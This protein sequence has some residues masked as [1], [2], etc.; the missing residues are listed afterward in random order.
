MTNWFTDFIE[1]DNALLEE[2]DFQD[3]HIT[4]MWSKEGGGDRTRVRHLRY[5]NHMLAV[6]ERYGLL[7][8]LI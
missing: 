4:I 6:W 3:Y 1:L 5:Q 8:L 7:H 2:D